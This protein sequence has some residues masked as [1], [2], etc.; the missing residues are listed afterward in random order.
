MGKPLELDDAH[1]PDWWVKRLVE[2]ERITV[3]PPALQLRREDAGLDEA[4]DRLGSAAE[5]RREVTEFNER[6]RRIL[7]TTHGGPP[8][9]TSPRDVE[10]EVRRWVARREE[11]RAR[12]RAER[13]ADVPPDEVGRARRRWFRRTGR[14]GPSNG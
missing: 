10:E 2:R 13:A 7:Y 12:Q 11:R 5:V 3:P 14:S 8:V 4:L 9:T 6:V 1:D